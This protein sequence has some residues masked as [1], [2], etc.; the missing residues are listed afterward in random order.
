QVMIVAPS[1]ANDPNQEAPV[2][3]E[4][5]VVMKRLLALQR[6][7]APQFRASGGALRIGLYAS[8]APITDV[9]ARLAEVRAGLAANP[10]IRQLIPFDSSTL[11]SLKA[12]NAEAGRSDAAAT[13]MAPDVNGQIPLLHQKTQFIARPGAIAAL[14]RQ[15]GWDQILAQS[16]RA[17]SRATSKLAADAN[18][19]HAT[20]DSA[21]IQAADSLFQRY[22]RA[23]PAAERSRLSFYF[24]L[25]SLNHDPRGLMLD[26]EAS[27]IVSGFA[28]SSG[29]V[30]LFYIMTRTTWVTSDADIDRLLPPPRGLLARIAHLVRLAM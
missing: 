5:R 3:A 26:G 24:A 12:A 10:W 7:M 28:A 25:G 11:A 17:Q 13:S 14:V 1:F 8:R 18:A 30:D 21:A 15:P 20:P 29:L 4:Q 16:I 22:Q 27:M 6:D 9:A 23:I 19:D 2:I